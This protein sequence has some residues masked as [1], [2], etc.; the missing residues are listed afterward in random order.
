MTGRPTTREGARAEVRALLA[1]HP[2]VDGHN[3]LPWALRQ[4]VRYDLAARDLTADQSAHLHTDLPRLRAGGVGAQYWSV[5]VRSDLA[6]DEA[7]SATLEQ[8]DCVRQLLDR[9][10]ADLAPAASAAD[11]ERA[12]GE[13]RIAS[14]MGAE[15]GHSINSSLAT[16]RALYAL[17]VRYLTLTHNDNV[18]WAD[19]ATDVPAAGG[20]TAFGHEVVREM[21]RLG[22][23]VDLSHTAATT[24]RDALD[25]S[26][27]P[28]VFS[29]SSARAV[30]D[31]PRNV[32]DDV[33]ERL[34]ANGGVAMATFVPKFVL[35]AAV[36]WTAAADENLR[37]H[38]F[39]PLDTSPAA[40]RA[41]RAFEAERPRPVAR[42]AD[43]ADHLDHMR[44]VA[45]VDHLGLGGDYDGT[46]F[47]PDGLAD[48]SGYPNLLVEL[49]T[50]G[51]ST[52]DLAKLTW[53]NAVRV[54][55]DAEAVARELRTRRPPSNA[56]REALDGASAP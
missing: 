56:T 10:P 1:D 44:E 26:D 20:L 6:G 21:N 9:Y 33:L 43:V 19:S 4:Q 39:H 53:S 16:L 3:D 54:L 11:L 15:G 14:L 45:G 49:R 35:P 47:T 52:A 13:G 23:L 24:M 50:R 8:I 48:V 31:H 37:A 5:Y 18:P 2:V 51:W 42:V 7:V 17:G 25:T 41:H 30:C 40:M 27:A 28:V 36:E 32:P 55:A 34:P 38:G 22:M 46:A 12:R 29:H